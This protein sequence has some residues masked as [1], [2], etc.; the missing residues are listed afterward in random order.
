MQLA[1]LGFCR[2]WV[3]HLQS[4][5]GVEI[6]TRQ[7]IFL[8]F[9][10]LSFLPAL[11]SHTDSKYLVLCQCYQ[12]SIDQTMMDGYKYCKVATYFYTKVYFNKYLFSAIRK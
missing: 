12:H 3:C 5:V 1:Y 11:L 4:R 9:E 6:E 2:K 7:N 10:Q 8:Q